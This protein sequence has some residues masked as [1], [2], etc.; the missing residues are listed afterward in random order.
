MVSLL[1][2]LDAFQ[3]QGAQEAIQGDGEGEQEKK[4]ILE[5]HLN[6]HPRGTPNGKVQARSECNPIF[7]KRK[8]KG[9]FSGTRKIH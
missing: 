1:H 6:K 4:S 8:K 2:T 9:E 7:S 3:P 5:A